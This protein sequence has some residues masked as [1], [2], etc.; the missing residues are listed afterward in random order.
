[1]KDF[2]FFQ[3]ESYDEKKKNNKKN[4]IL[5][6]AGVLVFIMVLISG[7]KLMKN[8]KLNKEIQTMKS[9]INS[10]E[11]SKKLEDAEREQEK[12]KIL[13]KYKQKVSPIA[14]FIESSGNI[15][16]YLINNIYTSVPKNVYFKSV[17]MDNNNIQIQAEGSKRQDIAEFQYN[18]K[19]TNLFKNIFVSNINQSKGGKYIFNLK[20]TLKDVGINENK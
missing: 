15:N 3:I 7:Y 17:N 1:M 18:L 4:Y 19:E 14:E 2:N 9:Y 11:N 10:K 16:S 13:E 5:A 20:C 8:A 12:L 6:T